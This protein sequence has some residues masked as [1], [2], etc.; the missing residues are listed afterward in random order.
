MPVKPAYSGHRRVL[1][2]QSSNLLSMSEKSRT[3]A[4][5]VDGRP[6][7]TA[8]G[9][10]VAAIDPTPIRPPCGGPEG[11]SYRHGKRTRQRGQRSW[12]PPGKPGTI[13]GSMPSRCP[14]CI[15]MGDAVKQP[16][17]S[18]DNLI[19]HGLVSARLM[20]RRV[21]DARHMPGPARSELRMQEATAASALCTGLQTLAQGRDQMP[22]EQNLKRLFQAFS[23]QDREAL[24][25]ASEA[26]IAD[27]E[28]E[29]RH[30]LARELRKIVARAQASVERT[31][32]TSQQLTM[33]PVDRRKGLTLIRIEESRVEQS[34]I[35][36]P[37][38]TAQA[39]SR[40][41]IEH[42]QSQLLESHGL[43]PKRRLL[44]WGPPGCGKT[45]AAYHLA[46]ELGLPIGI[47]SLTAVISSFLGDT[48]GNLQAVFDQA[49]Q[50]PMVLLL[51]EADAIAKTREDRNDVGELK[52]VVNSLLQALDAYVPREG[53]VIAAT[54][55]QRVIDHAL[56]RRFDD[57]LQ[58][59]MPS[60]AERER[61]LRLRL[62]GP[63][64]FAG[65]TREVA[66]YT[67]SCS[68][69]DLRRIADEAAKTAILERRDKVTKRDVREAHATLASAQREA[70]LGRRRPDAK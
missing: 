70:G 27:A 18:S 17:R 10:Q 51:D 3:T 14:T 65:S 15:Q 68:F 8:R 33:F 30:V 54:N 21:R 57:V 64:R 50:R 60:L 44:F 59:R 56:W 22:F 52:R 9:A 25:R 67:A 40:I 16:T 24:A 19:A 7:F 49:S 58:F 55:Y 20:P 36:L 42:R 6:V 34:E 43:A 41:V 28:L 1:E 5:E 39:L 46:H 23:E 53:L 13:H 47:I 61:Y 35:I 11:R 2:L 26:V 31:G 29:N 45:F 63:R 32:P 37:R 38:F 4:R 48:A 62:G 66:K 69:A 12:Q